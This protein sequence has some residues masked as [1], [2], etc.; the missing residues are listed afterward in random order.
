VRFGRLR[1]AIAGLTQHVLTAQLR[2]REHDGLVLR[3]AF[4]DVP[5]RIEYELTDAAY[6]LLPA[7]RALLARSEQHG[8]P[9]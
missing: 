3:T 8:R 5:L 9:A 4:G 2:E 6:L 1:R 7:F